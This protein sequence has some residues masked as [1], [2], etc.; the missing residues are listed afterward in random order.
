MQIIDAS[1]GSQGVRDKGRLE[2]ALAAVQQEV[3]GEELYSTIYEKAAALMRGMIADHPFVEGNK[4]SGT[5]VS[6]THLTLPT[7]RIV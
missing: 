6:Y 4:R 2:T 3:F 5:T 1:G 7:K